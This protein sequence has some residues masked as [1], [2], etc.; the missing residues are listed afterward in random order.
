[1]PE[2]DFEKC[3]K[4]GHLQGDFDR[5]VARAAVEANALDHPLRVWTDWASE[6]CRAIS[7]R[8]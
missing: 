5:A 8:S 2:F 1:M 6:C 7:R 4:D 3:V